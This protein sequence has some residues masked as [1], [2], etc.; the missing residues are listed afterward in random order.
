METLVIM[1]A[2]HEI[3]WAGL[4]DLIASNI[5]HRRS[6]LKACDAIYKHKYFRTLSSAAYLFIFW[7]DNL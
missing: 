1:I 5:G 3:M 4:R 7:S 2:F 6:D